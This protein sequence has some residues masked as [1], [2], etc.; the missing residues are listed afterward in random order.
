VGAT[1]VATGGRL[2]NYVPTATEIGQG[3][4]DQQMSPQPASLGYWYTFEVKCNATTCSGSNTTKSG[5]FY[6]T[7]TN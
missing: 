6:V 7:N 4:I 2:T 3:F 5:Y 1:P